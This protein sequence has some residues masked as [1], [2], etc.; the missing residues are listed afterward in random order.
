ML[1]EV[2]ATPIWQ[3]HVLDYHTHWNRYGIRLADN[4]ELGNVTARVMSLKVTVSISENMPFTS[5]TALSTGYFI[6]C[7]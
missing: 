3:R 7:Q 5:P 4:L 6:H 1:L 2:A